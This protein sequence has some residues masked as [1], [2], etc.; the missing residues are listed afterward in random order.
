MGTF[1]VVVIA[2]AVVAGLAAIISYIGAGDVYRS[3]GR[4]QFALDTDE[5]P[6]HPRTTSRAATA[7]GPSAGV[8]ALQL[9]AGWSGGFLR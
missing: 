8:R 4:G 7:F 1:G 6:S 5:R 9:P 3:I 2:V